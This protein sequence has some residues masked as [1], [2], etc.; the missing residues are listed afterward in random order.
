MV[1]SFV[2]IKIGVGLMVLDLNQ[3]QEPT[4]QPKKVDEFDLLEKFKRMALDI[5]VEINRPEITDEIIRVSVAGKPNS[6][7]GWYALHKDEDVLYGMVGNWVNGQEVKYCSRSEFTLDEATILRMNQRHRMLR[8]RASEKRTEAAKIAAQ[9]VESAEVAMV[10]HPYLVSKGVKP[11]GIGQVGDLLQIPISDLDGN[12]LSL[13]TIDPSGKKLFMKDGNPTG[14]YQIGSSHNSRVVIAEGFATGASIHEATGL[15]VLVCFS[16]GAMVK[17]APEIVK[18]FGEVIIAGDNDEAGRIAAE[19]AKIASGAVKVVFP[20]VE[21]A[22]FN[23]LFLSDPSRLKE[24]F[25]DMPV[26][27]FEPWAVIDPASLTYPEILYAGF[28]ARGYSSLTVA[29]PKA[30]KSL[31]ALAEAVDMAT[32]RGIL[33][34]DERKPLRV[35]YYNAEDDQSTLRARA[36]AVCRNYG[37]EQS[38]LVGQLWLQSGVD[39]NKFYLAEGIDGD[40]REDVFGQITRFIEANAIDVVIFDPL[41]DLS[42]A[43]ETNEVFRKIG[44]RLRKMAAE[45]GVSCGLIHHLRKTAISPTGGSIAPTIND[46]RGGSALRG[47]SRFNRVLV[48]MSKGEGETV[49]VD[50][51]NYFRI[52]EIES[53][54]APPSSDVNR[55]FEKVSVRI[56]EA[57]F[58]VGCVRGWD[59]PDAFDGIDKKKVRDMQLHIQ[60]LTEP[61]KA[62]VR[63]NEW[64]GDLVAE[65]FGLDLEKKPEKSRVKALINGWVD[66]DVLRVEK[67]KDK[68]SGREVRVVVCGENN[69]LAEA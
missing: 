26:A 31:L 10:D 58:S 62:D 59:W 5:G 67:W 47:T 55:W 12:V 18:K 35:L 38:E 30:G 49:G 39:W 29:E 40:I 57:G 66:T 11:F 68:R 28:Y 17:L 15:S 63:S 4:T 19:K 53:N 44:R 52:G 61:M 22:D 23:D 6:L 50:H 41:Q 20:D 48:G 69:I 54:L 14:I 37:I 8:E 3:F 43:P 25:Q 21:G 13:Q 27:E 32:G 64:V 45:T 36:L 16:A 7:D 24:M 33:T 2:T 34:D 65:W 42:D 1:A 51:R 60:G 9:R 46:M 56:E